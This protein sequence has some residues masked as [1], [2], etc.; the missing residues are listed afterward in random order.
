[1]AQSDTTDSVRPRPAI[2]GLNVRRIRLGVISNEFF[3]ERL[4]RVG[5]FG[6]AAR[7]VAE[8]FNGDPTYGV[9]VVFLSCEHP[10]ARG[11][12]EI[13]THQTR[14][15]LSDPRHLGYY[16]A[17]R[18]ERFDLLLTI[19]YRASYRA[20]MRALPRTPL[21][22]WVRDPR[23][24]DDVARVQTLR[25]PGAAIGE[26]PQGIDPV[27][28][29]TL[30]RV[31]R[32]SRW[33]RRPAILA[34]AA[35]YL[36]E[37]VPATYGLSSAAPMFLPTVVEIDPAGIA[38]S[39]HPTV[40]YLGRFDP[41]KRP[42]LFV[43]LAR[44][45]PDCEFLMMGKSNFTGPGSWRPEN[46]PA[47]VKLLGHLDDAERDRVLAA[48]WVRVNTSVHESLSSSFLEALACEAPLLSCLDP[49]ATV[50]R[51]G[52]YAGRSDG[53]GM[54]AVPHLVDGLR[55]LLIDDARRLALGRAGRRWVTE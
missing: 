37:N 2:S 51:F 7:R 20:V 11:M 47:N 24:P 8:C 5:G 25:M 16:A 38:K 54:A 21:L 31:L 35:E 19:D 17:L 43:E 41:I 23:T 46:L 53:D 49:G 26:C 48:A 13:R 44:H 28:C 30:N 34:T 32:F 40:V 29:R 9:E 42:W 1:M 4:G 52:I 39:P 3:D 22:I 55:Q 14:L 6:Q 15:I 27:D 50:S 33:I 12:R 10:A 18:R 45:F 36:A